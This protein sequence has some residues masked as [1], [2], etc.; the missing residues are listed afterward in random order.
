MSMLALLNRGAGAGIGAEIGG[1]GGAFADTE[2][3]LVAVAFVVV[4]ICFD[5][6]TLDDDEDENKE[7]REWSTRVPCINRLVQ[8]VQDIIRKRSLGPRTTVEELESTSFKK[9][10]EFIRLCDEVI[11]TKKL[12]APTERFEPSMKFENLISEPVEPAYSTP[13]LRTSDASILFDEA[14][15]AAGRKYLVEAAFDKELLDGKGEAPR[16]Y[17][18]MAEAL[19]GFAGV[20]VHVLLR[21]VVKIELHLKTFHAVL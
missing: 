14:A 2:V 19:A 9:L 16:L 5:L 4:K 17:T 15:S 1:G 8:H 10:P 13:P 12:P 7:G 20:D 11:Y 3:V 18:A 6:A 21:A